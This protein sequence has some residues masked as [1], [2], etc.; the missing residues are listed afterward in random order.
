[1]Y[2]LIKK[3]TGSVVAL[4]A[5]GMLLALPGTAS[6][7]W[8][9]FLVDAKTDKMMEVVKEGKTI[10]IDSGDSLS[11]S[12][13]AMH[14]KTK[15]VNMVLRKGQTLIKH[16]VENYAP[17]ALFGDSKGNYYG[18]RLAAG[19]YTVLATAYSMPG[20]KGQ[21]LGSKTVNFS[22]SY[23]DSSSDGNSTGQD[24]VCIPIT[25]GSVTTQQCT[26]ISDGDSKKD[27]NNDKK[28]DPVNDAPRTCL[29]KYYGPLDV[30]EYRICQKGD[31]TEVCLPTTNGPAKVERCVPYNPKNDNAFE[32]NLR[33]I[34]ESLQEEPVPPVS[35]LPPISGISLY[36][37]VTDKA[38][39]LFNPIR[40]QFIREDE[41]PKHMKLSLVAHITSGKKVSR[42]HFDFDGKKSFR[43]ES[44]APY[45]LFGD[46]GNNYYGQE[47]KVGKTYTITARAQDES[48]KFYNKATT[49]KF[50][51][52]D[53]VRGEILDDLD[54]F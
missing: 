51:I 35:E 9:F 15:S 26:P 37:A 14:G 40:G 46:S 13:P 21:V 23:T 25:I 17:Y 27:S 22:L 47:F 5:V 16:Q 44:S 6:A 30:L 42:V 52:V 54:K 43:V 32:D 45:S 53:A 39:P 50:T 3:A 8:D 11:I 34:L 38:I 28:V 1:M 2:Q 24:K 19:D 20:A 7:A 49:V 31:E 4:S 12:A 10:K 18:K 33:D 29:T 41:L 36:D 48:G